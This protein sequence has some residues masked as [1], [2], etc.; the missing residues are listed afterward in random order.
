MEA[1]P[2][3]AGRGSGRRPA[4]MKPVTLDDHAREALARA[5]HEEHLRRTAADAPAAGPLDAAEPRV[6]WQDL[7][8]EARAALRRRADDIAVKM[9]LI[10]AALVPVDEALD[11][12]SRFTLPEL[13]ILSRHEHERWMR[14]KTAA[15]WTRGPVLDPVARTHPS[16]VGYEELPEHEKEKDRRVVRR[17][18]KL[19]RAVD[20]AIA[21]VRKG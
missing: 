14:E 1:P 17:I 10:G 2:S 4:A 11:G 13:E 21:R 5:I 9:A 20:I 15:G 6:P 7:P 19:L 18:P 3:R 16:L 12:E 8:E